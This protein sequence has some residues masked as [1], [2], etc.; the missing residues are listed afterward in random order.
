MDRRR[1][2]SRPTVINRD[3]RSRAVAIRI[4][5]SVRLTVPMVAIAIRLGVDISQGIVIAMPRP[6]GTAGLGIKAM[7]ISSDMRRAS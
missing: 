4:I 5:G 1:S 3:D 7:P 2:R 6:I